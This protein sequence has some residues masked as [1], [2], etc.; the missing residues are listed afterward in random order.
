MIA[1]GEGK[2]LFS[3]WNWAEAGQ[4]GALVGGATQQ[5]RQGRPYTTKFE[6]TVDRHTIQV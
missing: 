2:C 3:G 1:S 4:A 5:R 6:P